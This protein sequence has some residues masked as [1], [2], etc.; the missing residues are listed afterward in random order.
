MSTIVTN[1]SNVREYV[2]AIT[3]LNIEVIRPSINKCFSEFKAEANKIFYG[4]GAIKSVGF[5]AISNIINE[6][7]KNGI[8]KSF[9]DF[10][11]RIN[12]K[13]VNKLQLE[14]LVKAGTFDEIDHNRKKLI[15]SIPKIISTIKSKYDEKISNQSNLFDIDN[16][17]ENQSFEFETTEE[18][19]K[20][21][22]LAEE[23]NSLGFYISD[24]PLNEYKEFFAQLEIKS[25]KDFIN[26]DKSE[27]LVAGT[28]M[29]I[30]EK[31]SAKGSSFAIIKFSDNESEFEIFLFSD[32]LN[33]NRDK[34]K[35]SNSFVF[36][37]KKEKT[38]A[39][40]TQD[41]INIKK[42]IDLSDLVNKTYESISIELN[43]K[44]KIRELS[45]LLIKNGETKI[46]IIFNE[47]N[48]KL[49]FELK[50]TRKF[51]FDLFCLIKNKEY[52]KKISF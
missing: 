49:M 52:I 18:W 20:K 3:R 39:E 48:K 12:P 27:A 17:K 32:L 41:R 51:D 44:K 42:L 5:E 38:N 30:Q 23:F 24:H 46:N 26:S 22:L 40:N 14:G 8:F 47:N 4:L 43:D 50:Q 9:T 1:T 31:K 11:N 2:E 13:D 10:I 33:S 34:L 21:E 29:S 45:E 15:N 16:N 35:E 6:R 28:I 7:E 36:T 19:S 25:Y 37:L